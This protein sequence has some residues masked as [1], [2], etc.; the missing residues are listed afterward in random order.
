MR[1][2]AQGKY[3]YKGVEVER[4]GG[5]GIYIAKVYVNDKESHITICAKTQAKFK[6]LFNEQVALYGGLKIK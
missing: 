1:K 6:N 5:T 2:I 3:I 4:F